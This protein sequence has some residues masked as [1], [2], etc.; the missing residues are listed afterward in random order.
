MK[1]HGS[2]LAWWL[3]A[4]LGLEVAVAYL[5]FAGDWGCANVLLLAVRIALLGLVVRL[6]PSLLLSWVPFLA[7][8]TGEV[9][10]LA[11]FRGLSLAYSD[12][13]YTPVGETSMAEA[14]GGDQGPKRIVFAVKTTAEVSDALAIPGPGVQAGPW[15]GDFAFDKPNDAEQK[16]SRIGASHPIKRIAAM[17]WLGFCVTETSLR[18]RVSLLAQTSLLL[19]AYGACFAFQGY[20]CRP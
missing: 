8:V 1:I 13:R 10:N 17:P 6:L 18:G 2:F 5:Y 20:L 7:Q 9:C 3:G 19:L 4:S 16:L 12:V 14:S 11:V 15:P